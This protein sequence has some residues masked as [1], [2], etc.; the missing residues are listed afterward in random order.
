MKF[1]LIFAVLLGACAH[2]EYQQFHQG[3]VATWGPDN[4]WTPTQSAQY[5][6][7]LQQFHEQNMRSSQV[8]ARPVATPTTT[9]YPLPEWSP[10]PTK[11][12]HATP[13]GSGGYNISPN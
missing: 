1:A 5:L 10:T 12:F 13:D 3:F 2:D 9:I 4:K 11:Y 7:A 6:H 8:A